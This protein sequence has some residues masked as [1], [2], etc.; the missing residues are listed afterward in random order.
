MEADGIRRQGEGQGE[1][2]ILRAD[3]SSKTELVASLQSEIQTLQASLQAME[4]D[5]K[6][7]R[8]TNEN[9]SGNIEDMMMSLRAKDEQVLSL[10]KN[11]EE[12]EK[13]LKQQIQQL[14]T[15]SKNR[16][17]ELGK[18]VDRFS[19]DLLLKNAE[20]ETMKSSSKSITQLNADLTVSRASFEF[21]FLT[22]CIEILRGDQESIGS[23]GA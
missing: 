18:D 19:A 23:R 5:Q 22:S 2:I 10:Q 1:L 6:E 3:L 21:V 13:S 17:A 7:H 8:H 20:I 11:Y 15:T 12:R 9:L 14:Q 4:K 16:I